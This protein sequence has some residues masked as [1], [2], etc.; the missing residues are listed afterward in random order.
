MGR[1]KPEN[2]IIRARL[3]C[4]PL[5]GDPVGNRDN[6]HEIGVRN[7]DEIGA[8]NKNEIGIHNLNKV[9]VRN[10]NEI[11]Q[12]QARERDHPRA[13]RRCPYGRQPGGKYVFLF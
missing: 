7:Q 6:L 2:A 12:A 1:H 13:P 4:V 9:G 10:L 11:G 3:A 5:A 8:H